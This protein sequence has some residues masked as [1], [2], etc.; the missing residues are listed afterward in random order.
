MGLLS[1]G[2]G[3]VNYECLRLSAGIDPPTTADL[4]LLVVALLAYYFRHSLVDFSRRQRG[5]LAHRP[6]RDRGFT[7]LGLG[8]RLTLLRPT[9]DQFVV[10][11]VDQSLSVGDAS[12]E[13]AESLIRDAMKRARNQIPRPRSTSPRN[14]ESR[15][16]T[17][18]GRCH[19]ATRRG[20]ILG[21]RS[22]W[23]RRR[24]R[25]PAVPKSSCSRTGT[26][27][28]AMPSRRRSCRLADRYRS[29]ENT[30]GAGGPG[31]PRSASLPRSFRG[32]RFTSR[33]WS[34]PT[35]TTKETLK[36]IEGRSRLPPS[37]RRSR[38]GK[39]GFRFQQAI[40]QDRLATYTA[41]ARNFRDEQQD[42]NSESGLVFASG[43]PR[44]LVI[45]SDPKEAKD[46]TWS[47]GGAGDSGRRPSPQGMPD[48][49][50]DLQNY[51]LLMIS[52]VPA[53]RSPPGRW[54]WRG[55]TYA[56]SA[57]A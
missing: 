4:G 42:N 8:Q 31:L 2:A 45:E 40:E 27:R 53:T 41:R 26:R 55:R 10:F 34:T 46:L 57:A 11:A 21:L 15:R 22:R 38:R 16:R 39:I 6:D 13:A 36:S 24:V 20:R 44:V 25:R 49:L 33:S 5:C 17:A 9:R 54:T 50:A 32:S 51:E 56:S 12:R 3:L 7:R 52:N 30:R 28:P 35:M 48:S 29:S 1:T 19:R 23:P 18:N 43:K 47:P 14:R 37:A